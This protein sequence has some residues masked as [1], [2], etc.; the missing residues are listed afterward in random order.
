M[1]CYEI[2]NLIADF[3]SYEFCNSLYGITYHLQL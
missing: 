2:D 3:L 1:E